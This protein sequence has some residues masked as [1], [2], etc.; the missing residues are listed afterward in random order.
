MIGVMAVRSATDNGGWRDFVSPDPWHSPAAY[1]FWQRVPAA[2]EVRRQV[3]E[4][5]AAGFRSFQV[6]SRM[7]L[8]LAD[9]LS[10]A[11]LAAFR[12]AVEEADRLGMV[13]GLYDDYNWQSGHAAGLAVAGG[14]DEHRERHLFWS[15][16]PVRDGVLEVTVSDVRA[17]TESLGPAA[18]AWHFE[19]ARPLWG[20]WE[21]IAAIAGDPDTGCRDVTAA[22]TIVDASHVGCRLRVELPGTDR[23]PVT[24]LVGA[25][26]TSSRLT[27]A[28]DPAAVE[29]FAEAGYRPLLDAARPHLGGTVAYLFFD[30]PH[31]NYYRWAEHTGELNNALPYSR[32]FLDHLVDRWGD[33]LPSVLLAVLGGSSKETRQRRV[34][35]WREYSTWSMETWLGTARRW[36]HAHNL[37]LSGHEVLGHVGSWDFA[38]AFGDWDLRASFGM[39][40][41]G[42]DAYRDLTA[43]DAQDS[44]P[45][46]A[47]KLAD[48]VARHSG[49][50]GAIIEQYYAN[51]PGVTGPYTGHWGLTP[52][53]LRAQTIRHHLLGMRQLL[54]HGFYLSDG[55]DSPVRF[56]NPRFDF[57]PGINFEPWF[58]RFHPPF[59][60]LSGRLSEFLDAAEPLCDVAVLYPLRSLWL[61]GQHGDHAAQSRGWFGTLI[62]AGYEFHVVD[63]RDL[64]EAQVQDGRLVLGNR[65]YSAVVLPGITA[66]ESR[67]VLDRLR[68]LADGGVRVLATGAT[69][70]TY[71]EG[72][73]SAAADWAQLVATSP[74]VH[75]D[76]VPAV[77][78]LPSVL[79]PPGVDVRVRGDQHVWRRVGTTGSGYQ[80]ALF[81]DS[82]ETRTATVTLPSGS[83]PVDLEWTLDP[84]AVRPVPGG[85]V[86]LVLQPMELRLFTA[87]LPAPPGAPVLVPAVEQPD[88]EGGS[89]DE[90]VVIRLAR[91]WTVQLQPSGGLPEVPEQPVSVEFGLEGQGFADFSGTATYR[92]EVPGPA[93]TSVD[94]V[95]PAVVGG[96]VVC[97]NGDPVGARGWSPYRFTIPA[98]LVRPGANLLE[99][100]VMGTAAN[101]YYAKTGMRAAPEP[102]GILRSPYL[103]GRARPVGRPLS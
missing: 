6:Q 17:S 71:Q 90:I 59:A 18:M 57:P 12:I 37:A 4:L 49:R 11:W 87:G 82:D 88:G 66:V 21:V 54:F 40:H 81:N 47:A 72:P 91:G 7:S 27:N 38:G 22:V 5:H 62:Q 43:A 24:V 13:V 78:E 84:A 9:H 97:L 35:F 19:G 93:L 99:I 86:G 101:R 95:L 44:V 45:Q 34:Q 96:V 100:V 58:A 20:D 94:L 64:A 77:G 2:V 28:M 25:R 69:V 15:T 85:G 63:E 74:I 75:R 41:F 61:D 3:A 55:D 68:K 36:A 1:W 79:G 103:I 73:G 53:E 70:H 32:D 102:A 92:V 67:G 60:A 8:P 98:D 48:S 23:V 39:D 16:G 26:C 42:V 14:H 33:Q 46:L 50:S 83:P 29:R 76:D 30:Q 31:T 10:P 56:T 65:S 52:G 89:D 51:P 80:I